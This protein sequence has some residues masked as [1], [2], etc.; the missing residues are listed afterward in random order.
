MKTYRLFLVRL[1]SQC[2]VLTAHLT[3]QHLSAATQPTA[4]AGAGHRWQTVFTPMHWQ[5]NCHPM[6]KWPC[7]VSGVQTRSSWHESDRQRYFIFRSVTKWV[8]PRLRLD[9]GV[10]VVKETKPHVHLVDDHISPNSSW[11][12]ML[13]INQ[14][15]VSQT[16]LVQC[17]PPGSVTTMRLSNLLNDIYLTTLTCCAGGGWKCEEGWA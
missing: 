15:Y 5:H 13:E 16:V 10:R 2:C 7:Y 11:R 4:P 14:C 12:C 8:V 9:Y 6:D 1:W 17:V 3:R